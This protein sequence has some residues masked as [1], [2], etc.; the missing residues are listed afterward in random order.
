MERPSFATRLRRISRVRVRS[1]SSPKRVVVCCGVSHGL[2]ALWHAL[3][4]RGARRIAIEDP[5]W[6]WQRFTVEHAGLEAVPIR[7]DGDGLVVDELAAAS[8]D[9]VV[10]T[11]AHQYPTGVVMTARAPWRAARLGARR[12]RR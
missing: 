10:L 3:R 1:S 7:I 12:A 9:A 11:P 2:S 5:G 8:A 4:R 6:R